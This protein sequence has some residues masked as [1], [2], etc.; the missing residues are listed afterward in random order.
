[1][2]GLPPKTV[3]A[4]IK[5]LK[6]PH[7]SMIQK[8][9][10]TIQAAVPDAIEGIDYGMPA[11]K[12]DGRPLGYFGAFKKHCSYFPVGG[13]VVDKMPETDPWR[14]SKGTMQFTADNPIPDKIVKKIVKARA[15]QIRG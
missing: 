13:A 6:E 3:D 10:E 15:A 8:M 14:T 11:F 4:Y 12:L 9:R 1:M 5:A 7:K 2:R